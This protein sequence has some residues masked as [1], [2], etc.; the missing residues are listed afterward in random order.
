MSSRETILNILNY[1]L[2]MSQDEM[3]K[4]E[5]NE[6]TPDLTEQTFLNTYAILLVLRDLVNDEEDTTVPWETVRGKLL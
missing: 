2:A 1:R 3:K 4:A 5:E 6:K